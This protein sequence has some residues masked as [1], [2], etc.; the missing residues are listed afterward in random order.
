MTTTIFVCTT[1]I[2]AGLSLLLGIYQLGFNN[3]KA[4]GRRLEQIERGE[5]P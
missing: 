5:E 4:M 1:A 2:V 3:G